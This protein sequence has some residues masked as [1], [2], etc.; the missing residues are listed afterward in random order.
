MEKLKCILGSILIALLFIFVL[1]SR[2]NGSTRFPSSPDTIIE[3][4]CSPNFPFTHMG[5]V[6][7]RPGT[8][9]HI[10]LKDT[11]GQDSLVINLHVF[12]NQPDTIRLADCA[13]NFPLVYGELSFYGTTSQMLSFDLDTNGCPSN[14]QF[15]I[16][17]Y[18]VYQD[19][20]DL[21]ICDKAVPF[22]FHDTTLTESGQ[23]IFHDT[24]LMGCDSTTVLNLFIHLSYEI[25]DT[26]TTTICS[27]DL[28]YQIGEQTFNETGVFDIIQTTSQGC[29]S[30]FTHLVLTVV[31]SQYDTLTYTLCSNEFPFTLDSTH[32]YNTAG[33][34]YIVHDDTLPCHR[35]TTLILNESP[36]YNDTLRVNW[37]LSNGA[38]AFADTTFSTSVEYTFSTTTLL[39]CDSITTLLLTV[40]E[41]Y[42]DT[43]VDTLHLCSYELPYTFA[44][45]SITSAGTYIFDLKTKL[46]CDSTHYNLEIMVTEAPRDTLT[47]Y[48]C[49]NDFPYLY[50]DTLL[51]SV[52]TYDLSIPDTLLSGCDTLR[53]LIVDSIP[54]HHDSLSVTVCENTPYAI[55][56]TLLTEVGIYNITL[57]SSLGCDSLITLEL[58]HY[59]VYHQ[60]TLLFTICENALPFVYDDTTFHTE[61]MHTLRYTSINGCD[62][63]V[64][65]NLTI[66]PIIYNTD[67]LYESICHSQLPY[68]TSFGEEVHHAGLHTFTTTSLTTGC[69]SVFYYHLTVY[70]NPTPSISG[71]TYLCEGS[72][73]DLSAP[74]GFA[75][76]QW[77]TGAN[78]Q[79]IT[80]QEANSY[81]LT[82]TDMHGCMG[83]ATRTVE[84][85]EL[86]TI[87]LSNDQTI[88]YGNA[89]TLTV[90]GADH[91]VWDS[92]S[93]ESSIEV[94]PTTTTTY[95]VTA[96]S[97]VS[98]MREG[99]ITVVVNALPTATI[100]GMEAICQ[101]DSTL[102]IASGGNSYRWSTG[103]TSHRITVSREESYTVTV[104]DAN[105]CVNTA[106]KSIIVHPLPT[107][108]IN[109][110]TPF[111]QNQSTTLTATGALNYIWNTGETT[112]TITTSYASTYSV[113]GTD[114]NGCS[115]S[116][117]KQVSIKQIN[118]Q[119]TGNRFFCHGQSTI[120]SVAGNENYTYQWNDGST[121]NSLEIYTAGDY[122]VSVTNSLGCTNVISA[123]VSEYALPTPNITGTATICHGRSTI[124][125]ATGGNSYTW[126]NG[127]S[128][129][130]ISVNESGTYYVT[131]TNQAG[132]SATTSETVIVNPLPTITINTRTN[133]CQGESVS[134]YAQSPTGIQYIW[135]MSGQQS[136]LITVSPNTT[137]TYTVNV[138]D[139]NNCTNSA[140]TTINVQNNPSVFLSGPSTICQGETA[141]LTALGG[142]AYLWNNGTATNSINVT[143]SG[144]YTVTVFN[145]YNCSASQS[146]TLTVNSLPK[147]TLTADTSI[148][149]GQSVALVA[150]SV[151]DCI[152]SWS[153]GSSHRTIMVNSS[154]TYHVT[155]TNANGCSRTRSVNVDVNS[156]PSVALLG[157]TSFCEGDQ[158][159]LTVQSEVGNSYVWNTGEQNTPLQ[160]REAG[161]Y[162]VTIT[163]SYGCTNTASSNV[164]MFPRPVANITGNAVICPGGSTQ[165]TVNP[166]AQYLW[167]TGESTQSVNV[168]PENN[169]SYSVTITDE[170]GCTNQTS[171]N[172]E[173]EELPTIAITGNTTFCKGESTQL[174]VTS[175]YHYV[176]SNN[177][178]TSTITVYQPGI[179]SVTATND[180]GCASV[181]SV[182]VTNHE[183]PTLNFGMQHTICAGESYTYQLPD[184]QNLT[185]RWSNNAVGNSITVS[186]AGLYTV[187]VTNEFGCSRS[188]SDSL[189]VIALP[190]PA[191][192]GVTTI[193]RGNNTILTAT[194]GT[195]YQWS[196]GSTGAD[197]AVFPTTTTTY[198]VTVTNQQG[199]SAS[200]STTVIVNTLPSLIVNGSRSFCEGGST[201]LSATGASSYVWSTGAISSSININTPGKYYVTARN[202][203][204]CQKTDTIT[205]SQ[206]SNP[207]IT[208]SGD[209]LVC[210]NTPHTLTAQGGIN[211]QWSTGENSESILVTPSATT[212]YSVTGY[213]A[214][215]CS[216]NV[217]KTVV[218][219]SQPAVHITGTTTICSG[220]QTTL[221][222]SGGNSYQWSTGSTA[223]QI[224]TSTAGSYSV[225]ATSIHGCQ[226]STDIQVV[227]NPVPHVTL[228]GSNTL[229][230]NVT[231]QLI[232]RGGDTYR[233]STEST[234][235]TITISTGGIYSVTAT[236][237]YNCS[238]TESIE[239]TTLP[240]PYLF[241][242]GINELCEGSSATLYV[243]SSTNNYTWSTGDTSQSIT[244]SPTESTTYSVTVTAENGC[245]KSE[246]HLVTINPLY[247]M[248]VSD[249]ICQGS[250]YNQYGFSLP[251]QQV[252]GEFTYYNT[253]QSVHG[254][255]SII[256]LHLTVRPR[257]VL[258]ET[259][260]GNNQVTTHGN[261][262]YQIENAQYVNSYQWR[263][264]NTHWE[265]T[266]STTNNVYVN[267]A[268][269]GNGI[270]TAKAINDC[271]TA[272]VS[273]NIYC[274]VGIENYTH[275][276]DILLYPIPTQNI[277]HIN[278][279]NATTPIKQIQL[280]D[281]LGR[282]LQTLEVTD[283]H[284]QLDCTTY[285]AGHYFVRFLNA[286]GKNI[287]TRKIIIQQ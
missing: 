84:S 183:L 282:C 134:L 79:V 198:A 42:A 186:T 1:P 234:D 214:M 97:A 40:G 182:E 120:L 55:G 160:V 80:I 19:T 96:Y 115:S 149:Q 209:N 81:S 174:S 263:I 75:A 241:I 219:E 181:Q 220:D 216:T 271:G 212:T 257:P 41:S 35:I 32:T 64:S 185:Y 104:T 70:A 46:G 224:N 155:V 258:P 193:C 283:Q 190:T 201:T 57:V 16:T 24:T 45:S 204:N 152:Y 103:A 20:I 173:I 34:Y 94:H 145:A 14:H 128:N 286:D 36:A 242:N 223:P 171:F 285:R 177:A 78:S 227:V 169:T 59:P 240:A 126:S 54:I 260:S 239:V 167:S 236:N 117:E 199:C 69:D 146:A 202:S 133:I 27:H 210:E 280:I 200:A 66:L 2:V 248:S 15:D 249:Q 246:N 254:C 106:T 139:D 111:C 279:E 44:D 13:N 52:G 9:N 136:Q 164:T 86:P 50:N 89:A 180:L 22:P 179:Y 273:I 226:A 217:S 148:C 259:I 110:R 18:P 8:A 102:L 17:A 49:A 261:Q 233:W 140:Q 231:N 188:A 176:W 255:D 203:M 269:N 113:T 274:N 107:I 161:T 256:T 12:N 114:A 127:S 30:L 222:A 277:L 178:T 151:P 187:T 132:C 43:I 31:P 109:G 85:S 61:G 91:Y 101:G 124:L 47:L 99:F 68:T 6:I 221:T 76:Y 23:Y 230:E 213:D 194:G 218:V 208:I 28:P 229:C 56:D 77:N 244:V 118:A 39:G 225:T 170:Q 206:L 112:N 166:N 144:T 108:S 71:K 284:L 72:T 191:I 276:T 245:T 278:I 262:F 215:G 11:A 153:T 119:I 211:Y 87:T 60:D 175:G 63:I 243:F 29:D 67:T 165:L 195:S 184:D 4:I 53:H 237:I 137:T 141:T 88:C 168:T 232:A 100:S 129:A 207:T 267:I 275:N 135:P 154:G 281:P 58:N 95:R 189:I 264:S 252:A 62:S 250:T 158:T 251:P 150:S 172:V 7:Q 270:L 265:L 5:Q 131:V 122:S 253:L 147:F 37:C 235:S 48:V 90:S 26:I 268:Q 159:T 197:I 143:Q 98:C 163:N 116:A 192:Q 130:Y 272:E 138:T 156:N 3:R 238:A 65:I 157:N 33:T 247:N 92:G 287:D 83:S 82:V 21:H 196:N 25:H 105:H 266:N 142:N 162:T 74:A 51:D 125:R 228:L 10:V 121:S 93:T 73:T 38:Y 123:S 205:I